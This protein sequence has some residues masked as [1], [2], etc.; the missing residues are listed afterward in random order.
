MSMAKRL[1]TSLKITNFRG[2]KEGTV[3]LGRVTIL[4]GP[5][6]SGKTTILEALLL[7]NGTEYV[8]DNLTPFHIIDKLH[9]ILGSPGRGGLIY[10]YGAEV[11]EA[12]LSYEFDDGT[13]I[14]V[15]LKLKGNNVIF[16][17]PPQKDLAVLNRFGVETYINCRRGVVKA[18]LIR[19]ILLQEIYHAIYDNW[20]NIVNM[21][22]TREAARYIAEMAGIKA[23]DITAEPFG[24]SS[25]ALF[26]YL[27]DGSR[28]RLSDLGDGMQ[29]LVASYILIRFLSPQLIL[30]DDVESHMNPRA[31][32]L[33][34]DWLSNLA[35]EGKQIVLTT[36]S[37]EAL[38]TI[39]GIIDEAKIV[40]LQ[41][42]NG[43]LKTQEL[44]IDQV[45]KLKDLGMDVRI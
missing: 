10:S 23:L 7:L 2:I 26:L 5:N 15:S 8:F 34:A 20:I 32:M 38:R 42:E 36:H 4:V 18:L 19:E 6:G 24:T 44:N 43:I 16:S 29:M 13:S 45:E 41:L 39:A 37:L 17:I 14:N 25:N 40:K 30:W 1:V 3:R 31:L 33:L 27:E 9:T 28:I 35:K 21:R 12:S 11:N 22:I